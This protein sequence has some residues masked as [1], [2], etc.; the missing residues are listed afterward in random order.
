MK[1]PVFVVAAFFLG[2]SACAS[3]NEG[4]PD[5]DAYVGNPGSVYDVAANPPR[6]IGMVSYNPMA[7]LPSSDA[8]AGTSGSAMAPSGG[9]PAPR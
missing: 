3:P 2:L 4:N 5:A 9:N 1:L 7:P 8:A 6:T